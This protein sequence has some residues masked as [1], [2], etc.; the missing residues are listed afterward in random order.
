DTEPSEQLYTHSG[1][2]F[3]SV[4]RGRRPV[5]ANRDFRPCRTVPVRV[6]PGGVASDVAARLEPLDRRECFALL[7]TVPVGR[8]AV[9]DQALPSIVP[10]N[11][12]VHGSDVVIRSVPGSKLAAATRGAVVAFEADSYDPTGEIGWSVLVVGLARHVTDPGDLD[13]LAGL[14]LRSC[15]DGAGH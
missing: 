15:A 11:F 5:W 6:Q 14:A 8:I 10:V 1:D 12:R 4:R 7:A 13:E 3:G 2:L 9:T